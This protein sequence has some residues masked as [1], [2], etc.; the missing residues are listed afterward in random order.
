LVV[1]HQDPA[2]VGG[3]DRVGGAGLQQVTHREKIDEG[4]LNHFPKRARGVV[5]ELR[6]GH[7]GA[8]QQAQEIA[9][10]MQEQA[11]IVNRDACAGDGGRE[12]TMRKLVAD[13]RF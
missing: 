2:V 10:V 8:L 3:I 1:Q 5:A 7:A 11:V 9:I 6:H 13:R 12:D 4:M